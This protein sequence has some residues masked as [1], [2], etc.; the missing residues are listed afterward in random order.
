LH[1]KDTC[2]KRLWEGTLK[3]AKKE[4]GENEILVV[5]AGVKIATLQNAGIKRYVIRL[6][7]NFTAW[8]NF[9]PEHHRGRNMALNKAIPNQATRSLIS[10]LFMTWGSSSLGC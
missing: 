1:P 4:L 9:L 10:S 3:Y 5:D 7:T 8:R 6:A 2:E